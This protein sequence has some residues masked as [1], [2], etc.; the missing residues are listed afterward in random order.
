M[1]V[2]HQFFFALCATFLSMGTAIYGTW[3]VYHG[4]VK[5][6]LF[7]VITWVIISLI[8]YITMVSSE[9]EMAAYRSA[10]TS[11]ILLVTLLFC[12]RQRQDYI[13]KMDKL[14]F[15]LALLAIPVWMIVDHK[16]ISL[17]LLSV[18]E[19]LGITPTIRKAWVLP[20]D[21]NPKIY[22]A[23]SVAILCQLLSLHQPTPIMFGYFLLFS[24]VFFSIGAILLFRRYNQF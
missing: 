1:D 22:L 13:T 9:E 10:V 11:L 8:V 15:S 16:E 21:L 12:L 14:T 23:T 18:I 7:T 19:L 4:R 17:V 5:P 3:L 20:Y 2:H 24:G 6:H